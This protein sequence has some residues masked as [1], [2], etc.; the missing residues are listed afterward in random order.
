MKSLAAPKRRVNSKF[1]RF[2]MQIG[3]SAK[4]RY[5]VFALEDIP[6]SRRVIEYTGKHLSLEQAC[7]IPAPKDIYIARISSKL[8]VDGRRGGSGAEFM[9][10]SCAPN[11]ATRS[12]G[13]HLYLYSRRK[14]RAGDELTWNYRYPIKLKRVPCRCGARR[15]RGT[16]RYVWG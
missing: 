11:L 2:R 15:C 6:A 13:R 3:R 1:A 14:I 12:I 8:Y 16:L 10:H 7:R 9:N 4:H 5:G